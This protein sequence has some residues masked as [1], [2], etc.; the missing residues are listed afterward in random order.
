[1]SNQVDLRAGVRCRL[2][3]ALAGV[4]ACLAGQVA[5]ADVNQARV[6]GLKYLVQTQRGDGSW[7]SALGDLDVQA[8]AN[9]IH[10]MGRGGLRASPNYASALSWIANAESQSTD[11]LARRA[12]ALS[13]GGLG[14][15][16]QAI[17]DELY[18]SGMCRRT[19]CGVVMK[20]MPPAIS[21]PCSASLP[22][23]V[24]AWADKEHG[25]V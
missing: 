23:K 14:L 12:I 3:I 15:A 6:Q 5:F 10:A 20:V 17:T 8:T 25:D 22:V 2:H 16:A 18:A 9:A 19:P 7:S 21:I 11:S 24:S 1:M 13:D 4:M